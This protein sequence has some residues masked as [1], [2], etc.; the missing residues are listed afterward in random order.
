MDGKG[1]MGS[2]D[3]P[4]CPSGMN[5]GCNWRLSKPDAALKCGILAPGQSRMYTAGN[6]FNR[7]ANPRVP[8]EGEQV[9]EPEPNKLFDPAKLD[10]LL[11]VHGI[12]SEFIDFSGTVV[13]TPLENRL[14]VFRSMGHK[15]DTQQELDARLLQRERELYARW[16]DPVLLAEE[17]KPPK[18]V[19]RLPQ[20]CLQQRFTWTLRLE[21]GSVKTGECYP[22]KLSQLD[23]VELAGESL[24]CLSLSLPRLPV[25]YHHLE[26]V[27]GDA[28]TVADLIVAPS[29]TW[30]PPAL[31]NDERVWGI[32][33][34]LYTLR[35]DSN[36][37]MGDYRDLLELCSRAAGVGADFILLN[38]LHCPD[39]RY[40]MNASPYSPCDRRFLNPL[41]IHLPDCEDFSAEGVSEMLEDS[42]FVTKLAQARNQDLVDYAAVLGLKLD[43]MALMYLGFKAR[44][45]SDPVQDQFCLFVKAGGQEL[46]DFAAFQ[47]ERL[48]DAGEPMG[49]AQFHC[50]LQWLA[51]SQ[52]ESCQ[53]LALSQG[54]RIGLIQDLAVGS[55]VD[56]CEVQTSAGD[57]CV[58]ARIGAP[59]D[60]FNPDGQNWGLPPLNP[61]SLLQNG[62]RSFRSL[63]Q[64]NMRCCG[65]LRID[66]VMSL[67]RLWWCPD[68][69]STAN[70]A[71][72]YYPV[73]LLFAVLKLESQRFRCAV[74][75]EDLGVVPPEIRGYLESAQVY[76]NCMF[77][78]EKYDNWHFR[79]P[80]HYKRHALAMIASHDVP[81]LICWWN[82]DDLA[83]RH[84]IGIIPDESRYKEEVLWRRGEKGQLLQWLEEQALL[85]ATWR[86]AETARSMDDELRLALV[87]A[88]GRMASSL[89]SIQLDD[90]AGADRPVNIPGTNKEYANWQ[91]KLPLGTSAIFDSNIARQMMLALCEGRHP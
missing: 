49:D 87:R 68:D 81:P 48:Q 75:G 11:L 18:P 74:I 82:E 72:V 31:A 65:A 34:Q 56:G 2:Q 7:P 37:G 80:E 5:L 19:L 8:Q 86:L 73:D 10:R 23:L 44:K 15:L 91:R 88:C 12:G 22:D 66:H 42:R 79:K 6:H 28:R 32:S 53:Q 58:H 78:F 26:L 57:Y 71:Y 84:T 36:W 41:Y 83:L 67:M 20:Y 90:L 55:I 33:T 61:D 38:P 13:R 63:L 21:D 54:M 24:H 14:Q 64:A 69:G 62:C 3:Q 89:V 46:A 16:L 9:G 1:R 77:Y 60:Y 52:L 35:S 17:G 85:P 70:G 4:N 51:R 27:S 29:T 47:A 43:V 25:G 30:Q 45:T 50:Y 59:P 39:L 40:P 76:S